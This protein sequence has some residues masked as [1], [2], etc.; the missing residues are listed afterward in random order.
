MRPTSVALALAVLAVAACSKTP[1]PA[2][3]AA[4]RVG[5]PAAAPAAPFSMRD[6][7]AATAVDA[8]LARFSLLVSDVQ[9]ALPAPVAA[10]AKAL[11]PEAGR[12]RARRLLPEVEAA[13]AEVERAVGAVGHAGDRLEAAPAV[14]AARTFSGKLAAAVSGDAVAAAPELFSARDA[15]AAAIAKYRGSRSRWRLDA[16]EP[17]GAER[18]FA[19]ARR[20]MERVES[21]FGSRTRVAPR[22]EGH[23]LD[24]SAA[25][26]TGLMAAQR[27]KAA[28]EQLPPVLR[29]PAVRYAASEERALE[30]VTALVQAP[31]AERADVSRRYHAAKAD[32]LAALADYF[33]A[34]SAR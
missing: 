26:M 34:L 1:E 6:L 33:A 12:E 11:R 32:A 21:A 15:L 29:A 2:P 4:P 17:Q 5:A 13:C 25:R 9:A 18:D 20:E 31:E 10:P 22:E 14:A 30:A 8:R 19:D 3:A 7:A 16:P 27:A 24:P 28:A 23:E